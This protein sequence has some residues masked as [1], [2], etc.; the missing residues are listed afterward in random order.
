MCVWH[1]AA[2]FVMLEVKWKSL[3]GKKCLM[4]LSVNDAVSRL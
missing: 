2:G 4:L 1:N 3:S